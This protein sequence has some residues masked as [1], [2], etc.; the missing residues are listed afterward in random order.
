MGRLTR[1]FASLAAVICAYWL[2]SVTAG[3]WIEPPARARKPREI[4]ADDLEAARTGV[5]RQRSDLKAWFGPDDWELKS[6]K[7]LESAQGKLMF[8]EY[9]N[10]PDGTVELI[11]CAMVIFPEGQYADEQDRKRRAIV[12]RAP[13]GALL[14]FDAPFELQK[15]KI[16]KLVGGRL[17]GAVR[18]HSD[19]RL[20]GPEDDLNVETRE[21]DLTEQQIT[22]PSLVTFALGPNQGRGRGMLVMLS[23]REESR[24]GEVRA[25]GFGGV[26]S[27]ELAREVTMRVHPGEGDFLIGPARGATP[28]DDANLANPADEVV[29]RTPRAPSTPVDI[30]CQG[31]FVFDLL[32]FV[33]T[34]RK[35]VLVKQAGPETDD[36]IKA[37][38][39]A[40]EFESIPEAASEGPPAQTP[41]PVPGRTAKTPKLRP[42]RLVAS[43]NPVV[44]K[45]PSRGVFAWGQ[46][47]EYRVRN[48]GGSLRGVRE[49]MFRQDTPGADRREI[50]AREIHF[51]PAADGRIE[52][53]LAAGAGW[54]TSGATDEPSRRLE[55]S[56]SRKLE[57]RPDGDEQALSVL[58][59]AQ[60]TM[61]DKGEIAGEEI[62]L[63]LTEFSP[64]QVELKSKD[65][66]RGPRKVE[67]RPARLLAK[68]LTEADGPLAL[69][70][71]EPVP[72]EYGRNMVR[73]PVIEAPAGDR[74]RKASRADSRTNANSLDESSER[75]AR[76]ARIDSPRLA[77]EVRE[78]QVWFDYLTPL[79]QVTSQNPPNSTSR[80]SAP[81][82]N[83]S[84]SPAPPPRPAPA[85]AHSEADSQD[86]AESLN[87]SLSKFTVHGELLQARVLIQDGKQTLREARV[88]RDVRCEETRVAKP[89]EIPL[90]LT[91]ESLRLV[92]PNGAQA[93]ATLTGRPAHVEGRG[94]TL[95][96]GTESVEGTIHLDKS[97]N[98]MWTSGEGE[99]TMPVDA[100][101]NEDSASDARAPTSRRLVVSWRG[102]LNFDGRVA[103]FRGDVVA[104]TIGESSPLDRVPRN[105]RGALDERDAR[106]ERRLDTQ[107]LEVEFDRTVRFERDTGRPPRVLFVRSP[108]EFTL[109]DWTYAGE[110]LATRQTLWA[111]SLEIERRERGDRR[112]RHEVTAQGPGWL[113]R[114]WDESLAPT[115]A[116]IAD[117]AHPR[118]RAGFQSASG[119]NT[120]AIPPQA[121]AAPGLKYLGIDFEREL[122]GDEL[123][124]TVDFEN[125]VRVVYG[126][127]KD[128]EDR[129]DPDEPE[130]LAPGEFALSCELL[131]LAETLS[132][133]RRSTSR[134][135][136]A[137]GGAR[138]EGK[139]EEGYKFTASAAELT[140][141]QA[142][143]Y[144]VLSGDGF[145]D[146]ELFRQTSPGGRYSKAAARKLHFWPGTN[147]YRG[148]DVHSLNLSEGGPAGKPAKR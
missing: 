36:E 61:G 53:F 50:H 95:T 28:R 122:R 17:R 11:P 16:G 117:N 14:R 66:A 71:S 13:E 57:M 88:Q 120:S 76:F 58:G 105:E 134:E 85:R 115:P 62:H 44:A 136:L 72:S 86:N 63:W 24:P 37:E 74:H 45:A 7:I 29:T 132:A 5:D 51:D 103:K 96:G 41:T 128:W 98:R 6:P 4:A 30:T 137:S 82:R 9:V 46:T 69:A 77:A 79:P 141:D 23:P 148:E 60:V 68:G 145:N 78:L 47:L 20:P 59:E 35:R 99:M 135:M 107:L 144:L 75:D 104:R 146:A 27:F 109:N 25:P 114:T 118:R 15:G 101:E 40:I 111:T 147:T 102:R 33:A 123:K 83:R 3:P 48:G 39:L 19:Q 67:L 42:A 97:K 2:Y 38:T 94:L 91:G 81:S 121:N 126:G 80:T 21:V 140:Y 130:A 116:V 90:V 55:V 8:Q 1:V 54:L 49:V 52:R 110:K 32:G 138:V 129:L 89:G 119:E 70:P 100:M 87:G 139:S 143:N 31:P 56:W 93:T 43:G 84:P 131:R 73:K 18:I 142:K 34:F 65:G 12:L 112:P 64:P 133:D 124:S 92:E 26:K 22:T 106:N 125:E 113:R 127:V 108:G 10:H